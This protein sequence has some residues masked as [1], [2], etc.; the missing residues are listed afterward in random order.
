M[1][2][3]FKTN[4]QKNMDDE[5]DKNRSGKKRKREKYPP[6][7]E[8]IQ[9]PIR[10][11]LTH[12]GTKRWA[13]LMR[14][15]E[16]QEVRSVIVDGHEGETYTT[17]YDNL[18]DAAKAVTGLQTANGWKKWKYRYKHKWVPLGRFRS[19]ASKNSR[20]KDISDADIHP[21][22]MGFTNDP[23]LEPA[24]HLE[25]EPPPSVKCLLSDSTGAKHLLAFHESTTVRDII[26]ELSK[27]CENVIA[28]EEEGFKGY[29]IREDVLLGSIASTDIKTRAKCFYGKIIQ[30][31]AC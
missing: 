12:K 18:S 19:T 15:E 27:H 29:Q 26:I 5:E 28:L 20:K 22:G 2:F 24:P 6:I 14:V 11:R 4:K 30:K 25:M 3:L 23:R 21:S 7:T 31:D 13:S 10:I 8:P 16:G 17:Q 9:L 1:S